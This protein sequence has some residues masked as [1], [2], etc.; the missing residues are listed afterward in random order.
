MKA[1]GRGRKEGGGKE[2]WDG[3]DAV[4]PYTPMSDNSMLGK[5][6]LLVKRYESGAASEWLFGLA[7]GAM[8]EFKHIKF[9]IKSQCAATFA[10][11]RGRMAHHR[12]IAHGAR[13]CA[14]KHIQPMRMRMLMQRALARACR[15]QV[16]L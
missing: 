12:A 11:P 14:S 6:E 13:A 15:R 16:S 8:V 1:P 2:D 3:T 5:F 10:A 4:R 9:N 7:E